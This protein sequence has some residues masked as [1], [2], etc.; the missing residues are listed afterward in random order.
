M[1]T[2][3]RYRRAIACLAAV[4]GASSLLALDPKA[5][6]TTIHAFGSSEA[7][8]PDGTL[9][10]DANGALYG[11]TY[12]GGASGAG[13]IFQLIPPATGT[14]WTENLLYSFTGGADGSTPWQALVVDASGNVYGAALYGG[15]A[16]PT[17]VNAACG[18]IFELSP[19]TASGGAWT[20]TVLYSFTGGADGGN[21]NGHLVFDTKGN[22]YGTAL[23]GGI[24]NGAC[25]GAPE[26]DIQSGCGVV[27]RL[28]PPKTTGGAWT[29]QV[30]YSF[31][32]AAD[33]ASPGSGV[34]L[35]LHGNLFGTTALGGD[36]AGC[37]SA[38]SGADAGCGVVYELS[39]SAGSV[40]ESV[41]YAFTGGKDGA[42][43]SEALL[44]NRKGV[45]Y[46]TTP[47]DNITTS[48]QNGTV[49]ELAPP[50]GGGAWA[51][52]SILNFS[53]KEGSQPHCDLTE[54]A[55]GTL[56]GTTFLGG[57]YNRGTLFTLKPP[58]TKGG[59]W[60]QTLAHSF[61]GSKDGSSPLGGVLPGKGGVLYGT[62]FTGKSS[63]AGTAFQMT[64]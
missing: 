61:T 6:L 63:T 50:S 9:V 30:L 49:F 25:P 1:Q 54:N 59:A 62:T 43:P 56:Y 18:V 38:V 8:A 44:L 52:T 57:K 28:E 33:G 17:C 21:P 10:S 36:T 40:V 5:G 19:P 42:Y 34:T 35:D 41:L 46:G 26:G 58:T 23:A 37:P 20:E 47:V 64:L 51:F 13:T 55:A 27:F 31:T 2:S 3:V 48:T 22:L 32:G 4:L 45:L 15:N 60:K 39:R 53:K 12:Y 24:V 11:P 14:T 16:N 7:Y 29:E